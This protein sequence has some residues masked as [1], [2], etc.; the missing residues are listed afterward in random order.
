MRRFRS[1]PAVTVTYW[2]FVIACIAVMVFL[3]RQHLPRYL[4]HD[5]VNAHEGDALSDWRA[6]RLYPSGINPYTPLGQELIVAPIGHPPTTIFWYLPMVDFPKALAGELTSLALWFF[7]VPHIYMCA[8]V[9]KWPAPMAW[10][11]LLVSLVFATNWFEYHF[12][13]IQFSEVI[14][15]LYLIAWLF[16]RSGRDALGGICIGLAATFKFFPI[17]MMAMLFFGWRWRALI[18]ASATFGAIAAIMTYPIGIQSWQTYFTM[19]KPI[20]NI[21]YGSGQNSALS[22][23]LNQIRS[24]FC[25]GGILN[26]ATSS[27]PKIAAA[28]GCLLFALAVWASWSPLRRA[29]IVDGTSIDLPFALFATISVFMNPWVWEHYYVLAIQPLFIVTTEFAGLARRAYRR[30]SDAEASSLTFARQCLTTAGVVLLLSVVLY[31]LSRSVWSAAWY[32]DAWSSTQEPRY[33]VFAHFELAL[34]VMPWVI[35]MT[36][37][38][39]ALRARQKYGV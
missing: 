4:P 14:A 12:S 27:T 1:S 21:W 5:W 34:K 7:I 33:H 8:K 9:L 30:W 10:T 31:A 22:G 36:L 18:W 38:F 23:L 24:P 32:I 16:L 11:A 17:V 35:P 28:G 19:Q 39:A 26:P 15:F 20:M 37:C 25:G 2:V 6:A 29:R 13:V 3:L